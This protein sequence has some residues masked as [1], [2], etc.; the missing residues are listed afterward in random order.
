MRDGEYYYMEINCDYLR[1][2]MQAQA[3][4]DSRRLALSGS[5][6]FGETY[7]LFTAIL[8]HPSPKNATPFPHIFTPARTALLTESVETGIMLVLSPKRLLPKRRGG[9]GPWIASYLSW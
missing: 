5:S 7:A 4:K 2:V 6:H 3:K 9:E 8:Y 1:R